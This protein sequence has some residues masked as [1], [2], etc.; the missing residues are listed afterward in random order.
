MLP[1]R[2]ILVASCWFLAA[3]HPVSLYSQARAGRSVP[4]VRGT[5]LKS[6]GRPLA[7]TEIELVPVSSEHIVV[8]HGL[9]ATS[10]VSGLFSFVDVP[11]GRY[12][13]SINF[14]DKPTELSPYDTFFYPEA[15]DRSAAR[16][17][18]V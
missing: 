9:N 14:D 5:L 15:R 17:F 3:V 12:T 18:E 8:D 11:P 2:S 16:I 4:T 7:Y 10:S 6:D 1:I 13:L